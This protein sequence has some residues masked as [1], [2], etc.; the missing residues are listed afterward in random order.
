MS[1]GASIETA[2][3]LSPAVER[4]LFDPTR[5]PLLP[6]HARA[7]L[8][9]MHGHPQAPIYRNYSG[10]RLSAWQVQVARWRQWQVRRSPPPC[11]ADA[12]PRWLQRFVARTWQQVPARRRSSRHA[13]P[14]H[15]IEP[16]QRADLSGRLADFV[17][18]G[19]HRDA[20]ICF[21]TTGSTGQPLR[22]PS[23][24]LVAA[25]YLAYQR[26]ALAHFGIAPRAG[27]GQVGIVL[28]GFQARCFTYVSVN[29]LMNHCG[30]AKIN[31]MPHEWRHASHRAAYLDALVP[32]LISGDPVS[33]AEL[34]TL[35]MAHRPRALLSTS[36]ALGE[37]LRHR[38]QMR[39]HV[40]VLDAAGRPLPRGEHGELVVSGGFNVCL[41]LLRYR[42]GDHA[43]LVD[44]P[45]G[46]VLR[47][48][49]GRAPVRLRRHDGRWVNNI[50]MTHALAPFDLTRY[51]L[52]QH[53]DG[54]LTLWV[55]SGTALETL[56]PRL[57]EALMRP[58]GPLPAIAIEP[59]SADDKLRQYTS[60]VP[61]HAP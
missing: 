32:E 57:R 5:L 25:E 28:A 53:L 13:P 58:L 6:A 47:D 60:D 10:H 34:A 21:T 7:L 17:P 1:P 55:D 37:G 54:S 24:P 45:D 11:L 33:L 61:Q 56:A 16:M 23:H 44:T 49:Q 52:H 41:P 51:A 18:H 15:E 2:S 29:P 50:E 27:R 39:L 12:P 42:T 46:P 14:W 35:P 40:E 26:R 31:L 48:L 38:L 59:L 4:E 3:P 9:W 36:M 43:R 20:L 8:R 30:L 22:V 19:L